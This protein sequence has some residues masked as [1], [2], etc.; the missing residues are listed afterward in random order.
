MRSFHH[1]YWKKKGDVDTRSFHRN[2]KDTGFP[3]LLGYNKSKKI[4]YEKF[5]ETFKVKQVA[6]L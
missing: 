3:C 6:I 5:L 2:G 1:N 4:V